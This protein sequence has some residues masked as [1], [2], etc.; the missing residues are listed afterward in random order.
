MYGLKAVPGASTFQT[1][2]ID[3]N[4][5]NGQFSGVNPGTLQQGTILG[6]AKKKPSP[7]AKL[8]PI[9][10]YIGVSTY[11]FVLLPI[12]CRPRVPMMHET[13]LA[14]TAQ[15]ANYPRQPLAWI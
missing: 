8:T 1:G 3:P 10:I 5:R 6:A 13:R 14:R 4:L 9:R 11:N 15:R 7:A 2:P 12:I